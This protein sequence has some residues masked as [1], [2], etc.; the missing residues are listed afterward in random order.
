MGRRTTVQVI[1]AVVIIVF[2][3]GILLTGGTLETSWLRF[4]SIA[5]LLGVIVLGAWDSW[6]WRTPLAQ[7]F[8]SVPRDLRGTWR[9]VLASAWV[10]PSTGK[11]IAPKTVF[12]V[13]RQT[14]GT[15]SCVLLTDESKSVSSLGAVTNSGVSVTLDYLYLNR[16]DSRY[17]GHSRMHHG[18]TVLDVSGRP[19]ARLKGRY[20][21]DRDSKGEL[22]FK[23]RSGD[24]VDDYD[25]AVASF[26]K[27]A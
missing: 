16:P 26:T 2:A 12:L 18:S 24:I 9:G 10:D 21:T 14:A 4:Y 19:A 20:W 27:D 1:A 17:E 13:I 22:D 3:I 8:N 11:Q 7:R 15:V 23:E 6:L 5:V 25:Q